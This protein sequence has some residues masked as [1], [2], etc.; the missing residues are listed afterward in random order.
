M[1]TH[2]ALSNL[3]PIVR[4]SPHELH[5]NDPEFYN[6]IYRQ[7]GRWNRYA[8]AWDAW[9][10]E[11]PTIHTVDHD[12]HRARRQ[13]IASYFSKSKVS[14]RHGMIQKHVEKLCGRLTEA[15]GTGE[16]IDL[17]AAVTAL[18][19][20]V[21]FDFILAKGTNSLD[22]QDFDV[23]ILKTVQGGGALWRITKHV[24]FVLPILNSIP[25]DWA[26]KI[27]DDKMKIF[28]SHLKVS[29]QIPE[30]CCSFC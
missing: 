9:G 8:F 5:V 16:T 13:P 20:D 14:S 11:G 10:A 6:T 29:P 1:V 30:P 3:G 21:A 25:L 2:A 15:A 27:S 28:F 23:E 7:D 12:R 22:R 17:G 24:G 18:V 4:I 26:I 19:R